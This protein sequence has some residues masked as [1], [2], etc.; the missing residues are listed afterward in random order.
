V[1]VPSRYIHS[2]IGCVNLDDIDGTAE[3]VLAF[4]EDVS[5]NGLPG[6]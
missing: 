6:A 1:S 3:L 2:A 5:K 4:L